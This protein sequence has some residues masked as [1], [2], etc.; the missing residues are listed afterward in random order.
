MLRLHCTTA[1]GRRRPSPDRAVIMIDSPLMSDSE[2][3]PA[4]RDTTTISPSCQREQRS[5]LADQK[6]L[7]I[8]RILDPVRRPTPP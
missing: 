5:S 8:F 2:R 7:A 1:L 6:P 4:A 3:L